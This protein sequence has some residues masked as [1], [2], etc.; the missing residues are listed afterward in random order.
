[1]GGFFSAVVEVKPDQHLV[2]RGPYRFQRHPS[3]AGVLLA[4]L[5][6]ATLFRSVMGLVLTAA[7]VV[8]VY[9]RRI[10]IEEAALVTAWGDTYRRY[11]TEVGALL[12]RPRRA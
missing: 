9:V 10:R 2:R 11:Q 5:G 4:L 12:P 1:L 3:Y 7:V 6:E 8:P